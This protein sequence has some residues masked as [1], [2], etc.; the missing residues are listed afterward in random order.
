MFN[1]YKKYGRQ[2]PEIP[3]QSEEV[4]LGEARPSP[5]PV[6]SVEQTPPTETE[7]KEPEDEKTA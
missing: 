6:A 4:A 2:N 1:I 3:S 5:P 7:V